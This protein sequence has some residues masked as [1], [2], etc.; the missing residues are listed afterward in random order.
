MT[1]GADADRLHDLGMFAT[2]FAGRPVAV[3][4]Q[5]PGDP[6]WTDGQTVFI[7]PSAPFRTN[8]EAVA[9]QASMIAAGS[10]DPDVVRPLA[11]HSRLAKTLFGDRGSSCT[12]RQRRRVAAR[13]GLAWRTADIAA[14]SDSPAESLSL[15]SGKE[16][17]DDPPPEFGV[18]RATKVLAVAARAAK[19][20]EQETPAHVPRREQRQQLDGPRRRRDRRHRRSRP[21]HQPGRRRRLHR[22]VAE[23]DAVVGAQDR[24]RWRAAGRGYSDAPDQLRQTRCERGVIAGVR[25]ERERHRS[26]CRPEHPAA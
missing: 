19:Q 3:D 14:R 22:Q 13:V 21:V 26:R 12:G 17:I 23:E 11:R 16:Q 4:E 6:P 8:L 24:K 1:E 2:A 7:D 25:V 5:L 20:A 15:A 9:V 10:L 18:I